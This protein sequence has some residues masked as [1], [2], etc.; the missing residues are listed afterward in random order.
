L[1]CDSGLIGGWKIGK[2]TLTGGRGDGKIVL[3]SNEGSIEGGILKSPDGGME[4]Q[5]FLTVRSGEGR[6]SGTYFGFMEINTGDPQID[7]SSIGIG[8]NYKNGNISSQVKS[9]SLNAGLSFTSGKN[10]GGY[11][12]I[13]NVGFNG[14]GDP[15][16][17]LR[18]NGY[19]LLSA[20]G[21]NTITDVANMPKKS[22]AEDAEKVDGSIAGAL[23]LD[24]GTLIC[25]AGEEN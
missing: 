13:S 25:T 8:I 16:L 22:A 1:Q 12:S 7:A 11:L 14:S 21:K 18:T 10:T 19:M 17:T 23:T 9:T 15:K 24:C 2:N 3:N 20:N 5:G 6:G 4:L